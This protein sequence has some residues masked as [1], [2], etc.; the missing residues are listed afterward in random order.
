VQVAP[1]EHT[2]PQLPQLVL[3]VCVL[4]HCPLQSVVPVGHA[5]AP[6]MQLCPAAQAVPHEPQFAGSV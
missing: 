1:V 2:V 6:V 4:T 3:L 5:Q